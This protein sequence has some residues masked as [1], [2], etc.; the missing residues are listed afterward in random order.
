MPTTSFPEYAKT[1]TSLIDTLLASA[2]ARLVNLQVD[3]AIH[4]TRLH[5]RY[6]GF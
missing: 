1:I 3:P 2:Q 6:P 4:A 5:F